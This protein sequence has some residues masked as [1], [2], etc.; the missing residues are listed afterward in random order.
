M[1]QITVVTGHP[2]HL[3]RLVGWEQGAFP[4]RA[5]FPTPPSEPDLQLS[6]HPALHLLVRLG[7]SI[8]TIE[9]QRLEII[10]S[11]GIDLSFKPVDRANVIDLEVLWSNTDATV[12]AGPVVPFQHHGAEVHH[13]RSIFIAVPHGF[14]TE[15]FLTKDRLR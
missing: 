14:Y 5:R 13:P 12:L 10:Q 7:L 8:M 4:L 2:V 15:P 3:R 1:T 6:L 9:A 11:V